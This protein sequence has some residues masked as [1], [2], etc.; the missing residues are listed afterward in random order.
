MKG[1]FNAF[2]GAAL[3]AAPALGH[4]AIKPPSPDR[5]LTPNSVDTPAGCKALLSDKQ[6]PADAVWRK[7]FPGVFR[8]LKGTE[9]PD[10]MVQAKSVQDV[11]NVVNFARDHNVRLTI[12]TTG[13]D[14][15]GR[16]VTWN[17]PLQQ[18]IANLK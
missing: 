6:W 4:T 13:H 7:A 5:A 9:A 16:L 11:Q 3:L 18:I 10:Y 1:A 15:G 8:K 12:I 2:L 17:F 14:F